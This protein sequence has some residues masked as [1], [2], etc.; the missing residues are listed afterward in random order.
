MPSQSMQLMSSWPSSSSPS[1]ILATPRSDRQSYGGAV[2]K[3]ARAMGKPMMP[4]QRH[5]A[6]VALEID[7]DGRFVYNLVLVTVPRQ[8]GKTTLFG[9]VLDHRAITTDRA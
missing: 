5:V 2:A 8:S 9:A 7:A 3:L 6:D 4:W 1:P